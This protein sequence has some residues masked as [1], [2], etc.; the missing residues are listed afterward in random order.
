MPCP[1]AQ[2]HNAPIPQTD[3]NAGLDQPIR[4]N[5][6]GAPDLDQDESP[7]VNGYTGLTFMSPI[8]DQLETNIPRGLMGFS[9]LNWPE[10]CQ[11]FPQHEVVLEYIER[12]AEEVKH[13]IRFSTQVVDVRLIAG[14]R[15]LVKTQ[16]VSPG[17]SLEI[18]EEAFDAVLVAN[19]HFNVHSIPAVR[20]IESW[21]NAYPD[22]I[23][24]SKFYRS[25]A[26]YSNKKT[27]VVGN[28]ASGV[29]IGAQIAKEC[30]LPL[31]QSEKS[32]S[33]LQPDASSSIL[34][35]PEITEYF[36]EDRTIRFKDGTTE[37]N[38]DRLVYC[39]GYFYSFPFLRS[40]NPPPINTGERVE[41]TYKHIFYRPDPTLA[42]TV[43]NQK[44]IPF[45]MAEAQSA[46]I[47][48]VWS[49]RLE[50]PDEAEM[51]AWEKQT[52]R[53]AGQEKSFHLLKFPKDAD[54]INEMY[55]W[56][57]SADGENTV[58]KTPPF[59]G[60]KE[61]WTRERFPA[62]KKTFQSFGDER[63]QKRTLKSAGFDFDAWKRN[64]NNAS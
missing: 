44:V 27:I 12:Y 15:W 19:G 36:V 13:L 43:L 54:Y 11:L 10:D 6:N 9:D 55:A 24:H 23:T 37:S 63:H 25:P 5:V 42:F 48:R 3:P 8:Y 26:D 38:V 32:E 58:G 21:N 20:G 59:W 56:A 39:T 60:E 35:K 41:S 61:Y 7:Q 18:K 29:D 47:A 22:S 1:D 31:L 17:S 33:Y 64:Q 53:E 45:P 51:R 16:P 4:R 30:Q 57:V 40:L 52:M 50:L 49:G 28:S 14:G 34:P 2:S 62:I 46:V